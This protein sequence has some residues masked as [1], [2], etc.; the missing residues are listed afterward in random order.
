M[1]EKAVL[2]LLELWD[3]LTNPIFKDPPPFG[4]EKDEED[5]DHRDGDDDAANSQS[6]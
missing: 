4:E 3:E 6:G 1:I 5:C 2:F